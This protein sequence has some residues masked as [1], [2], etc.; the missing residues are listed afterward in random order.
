M[1]DPDKLNAAW[2]GDEFLPTHGEGK[3]EVKGRREGV[4]SFIKTGKPIQA[5][6]LTLGPKGEPSF[7]DGRH[8][9]AVLR[10]L[11]AMHVAVTVP[12]SQ[13]AEILKRFGR[14][15]ARFSEDAE[16]L[17]SCGRLVAV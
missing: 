4:K 7:I 10:D 8:R 14:G 12:K 6:R 13:A 16:P 3:S 9:F 11:G 15:E 2:K 5:S 1:I 17:E